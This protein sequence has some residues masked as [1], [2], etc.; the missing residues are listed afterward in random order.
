MQEELHGQAAHAWGCLV[1][2]R[3]D[4][5]KA[6]ELAGLLGTSLECQTTLRQGTLL[7]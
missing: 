6:R 2:V 5:A 4:G 7:T 1:I 3:L